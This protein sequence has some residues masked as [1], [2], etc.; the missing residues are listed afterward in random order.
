MSTTIKKLQYEQLNKDFEFISTTVLH[1][2][3]L[4]E[5][6]LDNGWKDETYEQLIANEDK[7]DIL[8]TII[9]EKIP[10]LIMLFAPKAAELRKTIAYQE[11]IIEL[12]HIGDFLIDIAEQ[13]K[14]T[15]LNSSDY[16]DFKSTLKKIFDKLKKLVNTATFSFFRNDKS[17]AY[18]T[19]TK[20]HKIEVLSNEISEN[21]VI[22]FQEISLSS[23]DLLNIINLNTITYILEKIKQDAISI[24]KSTI[25]VAEGIDIKHQRPKNN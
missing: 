12:E 24:A 18:Q 10:S 7:I 19:I 16:T 1:Q 5:E 6:L 17:Q 22:A 3:A 25:F 21:L 15:N 8:E 23:Q 11:I 9:L 20:E 2:F 14:K 13:L 4:I